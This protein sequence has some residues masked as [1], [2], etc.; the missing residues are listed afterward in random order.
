[1]V[2]ESG[3]AWSVAVP[4]GDVGATP[5]A[6]LAIERG[7]HVRVGLEDFAG[8]RQPSNAELVREIVAIAREVGRPVATC[9]QAREILGLRR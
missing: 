6:R 7:G 4:G 3:L 5:L 9:D 1:M 8:P 2:A